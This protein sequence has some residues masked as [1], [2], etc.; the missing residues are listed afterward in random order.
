LSNRSTLSAALAITSVIALSACTSSQSSPTPIAAANVST[1]GK[2]QFAV[3]T[4]NIG[5][6]AV[7]LNVVSMYRQSN[8]ESAVLVN[9][10]KLTGAFTL[11]ATGSVPAGTPAYDAASTA[12]VGPSVAEVAGS[13]IGGTP[14]TSA[15]VAG[16]PP[17]TFGQSGGVFGD[18]F[19]PANYGSNG[20]P[21]TFTPYNEPLYAGTGYLHTFVAYGG[22]PAF[23]PLGNGT[24]TVGG[25][26]TSG[27]LGIPLG[28][29]VFQG[30]T[31]NAG[32]YNLNVV[33]PTGTGSSTTVT[34]TTSLAAAT[35]LPTVPAPSVSFDAAGEVPTVTYTLPAGVTGAYVQVIDQ[36]PYDPVK[37]KFG[38]ACLTGSPAYF[39]FWVTASGTVTVTKA[40]GANAPAG[41]PT[42]SAADNTATASAN[43]PTTSTA[44]VLQVV[45][46]GFDYN[47]YGLQYN[48][49]LKATYPQAPA[50]PA[51]A[52]VTISPIVIANSDGAST[53][54]ITNLTRKA[55]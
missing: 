25:S 32:A 44:D 19:A 26:F 35:L 36:G 13:Y 39:T 7:G 50:L 41:P 43:T 29:S 16:T 30:V 48:G 54:G 37:D 3:G 34:A 9:T 51:S 33:V 28:L 24:G 6:T 18:G 2:L 45:V 12:E 10:P 46:I 53:A 49:A 22:P 5:G 17:T 20:L 21:F 52:D 1:I 55:R 27:V 47:Q 31:A 38:G 4:A 42:C 11:P 15:S 14:Q 8:G 23:D 40:Y